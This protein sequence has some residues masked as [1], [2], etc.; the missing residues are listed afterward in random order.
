MGNF[1]QEHA[2]IGKEQLAECPRCGWNYKAK[3]MVWE[4]R[5]EQYV[6]PYCYDPVHLYVD[7]NDTQDESTISVYE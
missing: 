4:E 1:R 7:R 5:T 6:C 2:H 3:E